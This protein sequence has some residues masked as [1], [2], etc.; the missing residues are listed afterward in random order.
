MSSSS[1]GKKRRNKIPGFPSWA[2]DSSIQKAIER[3]TLHILP[4]TIRSQVAIANRA[5]EALNSEQ[6]AN[7]SLASRLV[8]Q[9]QS[10]TSEILGR[11]GEMSAAVEAATRHQQEIGHATRA[12][13]ES[14]RVPEIGAVAQAMRM[15]SPLMDSS[16]L[17][18]PECTAAYAS[19]LESNMAARAGAIGAIESIHNLSQIGEIASIASGLRFSHLTIPNLDLVT[20]NVSRLMQDILAGVEQYSPSEAQ[21]LKEYYERVIATEYAP[22]ESLTASNVLVLISLIIG[23]LALSIAYAS[24]QS[25]RQ[26]SRLTAE[27]REQSLEN[28]RD[29]LTELHTINHHC[30]KANGMDP[31][32]S[33]GLT[34][35]VVLRSVNLRTH[36]GTGPGSHIITTLHPNQKVELIQR[37]A[38]PHKK[39]IYVSYYDH[40]EDI[41][42]YGWVY[43]KYLKRVGS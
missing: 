15:M 22:V 40:I 39:W 16:Q 3:S 34:E 23:L 30:I 21:E 33:S 20:G 38:S 26:E 19:L 2:F 42:R 14:M 9:Q 29:L 7:A 41:P 32:Q 27:Y 11:H 10:L 1:D 36:Q 6:I 18:P 8:A 13:I 43:K 12:A 35:Y 4:E 24:L 31:Q 25:D 28:Q 17:A 37:G 5:V